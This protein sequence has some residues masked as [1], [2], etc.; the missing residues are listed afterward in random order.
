[1]TE[2]KNMEKVIDGERYRTALARL[3]AS[4][5]ENTFLFRALNSNYLMQR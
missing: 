4:D 3:L 2:P 1:M 5:E